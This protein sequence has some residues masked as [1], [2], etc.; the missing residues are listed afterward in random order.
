MYLKE[1][2]SGSVHNLN[3]PLAA[4]A[5]IDTSTEMRWDL[6]SMTNVGEKYI[7]NSELLRNILCGWLCR[8][9][10]PQ[11]GDTAL[12]VTSLWRWRTVESL[13]IWPCISQ[14]PYSFPRENIS[15]QIALSPTSI[16]WF[17]CCSSLNNETQSNTFQS[18]LNVLR[19]SQFTNQ[20]KFIHKTSS[21]L[22]TDLYFI[23]IRRTDYLLMFNFLCT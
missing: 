17:I 20:V 6:R 12:D 7:N 11:T 15:S 10:S 2:S 13:N 5:N 8:G 19:I 9:G 1:N 22:S 14:D 16:K 21:W 23:L 3:F 4:P 18:F